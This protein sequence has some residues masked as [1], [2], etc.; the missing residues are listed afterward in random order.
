MDP[1]AGFSQ[2]EY[3][4]Y[5]N[6]RK[7]HVRLIGSLCKDATANVILVS[8]KYPQLRIL[9]KIFYGTDQIHPDPQRTRDSL[10]S[11]LLCIT[12]NNSEI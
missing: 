7:E 6:F 11:E 5:R 12:V 4:P 9:L 1:G 2:V 10:A 8:T 3:A